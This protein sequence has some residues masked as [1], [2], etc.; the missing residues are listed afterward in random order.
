MVIYFCCKC[1]CKCKSIMYPKSK[2]NRQCVGPCFPAGQ[3][4]THPLYLNRTVLAKT[5]NK[6]FCPT[7]AYEKDGT[8]YNTDECDEVATS[9]QLKEDY[10]FTIVEPFI[11]R[12]NDE[13][14]KN[15]YNVHTFDD[16]LKVIE[17]PTAALTT[18]L[19]I[20]NCSF[21]TFDFSVTDSVVDFYLNVAKKLWVYGLYDRVADLIVVK[22]GKIMFGKSEGK[23]VIN[24]ATVKLMIKFIIRKLINQNVIFDL[25]TNYVTGLDKTNNTITIDHNNKLRLT[26]IDKLVKKINASI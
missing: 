4:V 1:K 11:H 23:N 12:S 8:V 25:L 10:V 20:M 13:F 26:L 17:S 14:L 3:I 5:N 22:D 19:R 18:K 7:V 15:Y 21:N 24:A 9:E 16:V 2:N 6:P